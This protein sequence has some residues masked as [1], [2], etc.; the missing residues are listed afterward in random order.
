MDPTTYAILGFLF[1]KYKIR[2]IYI[3]IYMHEEEYLF[4]LEWENKPL[5]MIRSKRIEGVEEVEER[6]GQINGDGRRPHLGWL[7]NAVYRWYIIEL[8]PWRPI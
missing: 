3:Y 5:Q 1:K 7:N 4:Y 2:Y 6:I 8:Y